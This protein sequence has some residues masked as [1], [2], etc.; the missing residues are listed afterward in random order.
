MEPGEIP[1]EGLPLPTEPN[2]PY[3]RFLSRKRAHSP[4]IVFV[5]RC[6]NTP[7]CQKRYLVSHLHS[8][9]EATCFLREMDW[10]VIEDP[11]GTY[12]PLFI[13]PECAPIIKLSLARLADELERRPK[14][15]P[16]DE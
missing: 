4:A 2:G 5:V 11:S 3:A 12:T 8:M 14:L 6:G 15:E 16:G 1:E 10:L 9:G 13:C 7:A